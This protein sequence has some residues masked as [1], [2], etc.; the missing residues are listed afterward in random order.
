M[1]KGST[2]TGKILG[3]ALIV[4][5]IGL[6]IWGYQLSQSVGSQITEALTGAERDRVM[7]FYI[8]GVASFVV[9]V[10]LAIK[11]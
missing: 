7:M 11:K 2:S 5:G 8:G 10:Y 4:V 6:A 3:L 1:A 9:G